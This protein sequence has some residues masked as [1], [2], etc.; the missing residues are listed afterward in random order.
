MNPS[1]SLVWTE[2]TKIHNGT[3][4]RKQSGTPVMVSGERNNSQCIQTDGAGRTHNHPNISG[5]N[6]SMGAVFVDNTDLYT[7]DN[8]PAK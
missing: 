3:G 1:H 6:Q 4:T 7:E 2:P 5:K 8:D